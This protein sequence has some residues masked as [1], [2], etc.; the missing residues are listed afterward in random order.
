[1]DQVKCIEGYN[2]D[3]FFERSR[4]PSS[5][6][7]SKDGIH[8]SSSGTKRLL[9]AWNRHVNIVHDLGL[10]V[11]QASKFKKTFRPTR[12]IIIRGN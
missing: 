2:Y 4:M 11:F 7:F 10:C 3:I 12:P 6:Y 8:L 5:R 9:D 1:M